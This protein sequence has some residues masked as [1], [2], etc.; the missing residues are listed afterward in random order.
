[1]QC[2]SNISCNCLPNKSVHVLNDK[3][4]LHTTCN[5][6][7]ISRAVALEYIYIYIKPNNKYINYLQTCTL[8]TARICGMVFIIV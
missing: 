2:V 1:M 6:A 5:V 8:C 3:S 7:K 4:S